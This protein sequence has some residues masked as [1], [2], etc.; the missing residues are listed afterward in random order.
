MNIKMKSC[1]FTNDNNVSILLLDHPFSETLEY[2]DN[3]E[4]LFRKI[5]TFLHLC[6]F[7]TPILEDKKI[8]EG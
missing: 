5:N 3:H 4:V 1:T 2:R 6:T 7:K 8:C